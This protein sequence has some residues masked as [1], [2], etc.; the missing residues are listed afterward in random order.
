[1]KNITLLFG[2]LGIILFQS[3]IRSAYD[4]NMTLQ[5]T[6]MDSVT[7]GPIGN[8]AFVLLT[9]KGGGLSS[10]TKVIESNFTT[11]IN[12]NFT[13]SFKTSYNDCIVI[14]FPPSDLALVSSA[15]YIYSLQLTAEQNNYSA[16]VIYT[17]KP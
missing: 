9:H 6:I 7:K 15:D 12:G 1:M 8:T 5:G 2:I 14:V 3:C 16:G 4:N 11:D 10:P 13:V 17:K